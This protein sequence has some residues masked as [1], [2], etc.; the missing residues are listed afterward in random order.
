MNTTQQLAE[1]NTN[2][3]GMM[4]Q[5]AWSSRPALDMV[6][7]EELKNLE[8][9][10][11]MNYE[12]IQTPQQPTSPIPIQNNAQFNPYLLQMLQLQA[13]LQPST[14]PTV[15]SPPQKD[16]SAPS[17]PQPQ[18][19]IVTPIIQYPFVPFWTGCPL[20]F[21]PMAYPQM[22]IPQTIVPQTIG[23]QL[24]RPVNWQQV[25]PL[26]NYSTQPAA[27]QPRQTTTHHI[28]TQPRT[29]QP[30]PPTIHKLDLSSPVSSVI[31]SSQPKFQDG[32][33]NSEY[34]Q[35]VDKYRMKRAKRTWR[36]PDQRL[37]QMAQQRTRDANGKFSPEA[38]ETSRDE[39]LKKQLE[40]LKAQLS[41]TQ[42][43]S[44]LLRE[45]L[46]TTERELALLKSIDQPRP[47]A[48]D[49]MYQRQVCS[50]NHQ[51]GNSISDPFGHFS[52]A[53]VGTIYS[54]FRGGNAMVDAF[55]EKVDF[56]QKKQELKPINSP[57]LQAE[58]ERCC[59]RDDWVDLFL[60]EKDDPDDDD[61]IPIV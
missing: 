25:Q 45:K 17:S 13:Q 16:Q 44:S 49:D 58:I 24:L 3:Q 57:F 59:H 30:I 41:Q 42:I 8:R 2:T 6:G 26:P 19:Q 27:Q 1:M 12:T 29:I 21:S 11:M 51:L 53:D 60:S 10:L 23:P 47:A 20:P 7:S 35:K 18:P 55:K 4:N 36:K 38:K 54:P 48:V 46:L 43:E 56:S 5:H 52:H 40:D 14:P 33:S 9:V 22:I 15:N 50:A 31:S 37:S 61:S 32:K 28:Q 34:Q 39:Q